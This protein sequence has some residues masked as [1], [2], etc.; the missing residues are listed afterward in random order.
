MPSPVCSPRAKVAAAAMLPPMG[1]YPPGAQESRIEFDSSAGHG[2]CGLLVDVH[3]SQDVV[4]LCHGYTS[5]KNGFRMPLIARELASKQIGSLRFDFSG[6]GESGGDF[7]FAGYQQEVSDLRSAVQFQMKRGIT[8]R[9]GEVTINEVLEGGQALE[10][11]MNL[12]M[13][14]PFR[15][16]DKTMKHIEHFRDR[17]LKGD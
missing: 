12:D 6:N 1:R 5:N 15:T 9:F 16:K 17:D 10:E 11:R 8:E 13:E 4:I 14:E 2:L 3:D 7:A